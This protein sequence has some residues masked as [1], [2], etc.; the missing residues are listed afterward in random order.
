MVTRYSRNSDVNVAILNHGDVLQRAQAWPDYDQ[1]CKRIS[2]TSWASKS[3]MWSSWHAEWSLGISRLS[4]VVTDRCCWRRLYVLFGCSKNRVDG[5]Y[6]STLYDWSVFL[7]W[8]QFR[9]RSYRDLFGDPS[10]FSSCLIIR[11]RWRIINGANRKI[12]AMMT[13]QWSGR[14]VCR[15]VHRRSQKVNARG[16]TVMTVHVGGPKSECRYRSILKLKSPFK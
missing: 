2:I 13:G 3:L 12:C 15:T 8:L 9:Y 11:R 1:L 10:N 6:P 4:S 16:K 5:F 14:A 7:W